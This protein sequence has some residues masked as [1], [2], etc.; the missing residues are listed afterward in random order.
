MGENGA[1]KSTLMRILAGLAQP[2][3][4]E[5]RL[6]GER[7]RLRHPYDALRRGICMIHQELLPFPEMTVAENIFMG[8]E[9]VFSQT[10]AR[11]AG[12]VDRR[13]MNQQAR[14]LLDRLGVGAPPERLMKQLSVAQMQGVEIAKALAHDA[15]LIIM[16]EPTSALSAHETDALLGTIAQL[17]AR[18]VAIVYVSHKLEEVFQVADSITVLRDGCHIA[19]EA[20]A[21]LT[22]E[23]LISLMVGR[24]LAAS[25]SVETAAADGGVILALRG[26]G[27]TGR[28][29]DVS[30]DLRR[31]E[32]LGVAGL[33]GAGRTDLLSAI[34]GLAPAD[35]G[36]IFVRGKS[37][38]IG[39][40]RAALA[41]GIALVSEDRK[42]LGLV[43]RLSVKQNVTLSSL[44]RCCRMGFV[45]S[46][47]ENCIADKQIAEFGIRTPSREQDVMNLSGGNQQKVVIAKA[48][49]TEPDILLLDE[50][51]RGI[52]VAA[53]AEVHAIVRRLARQGKAIMLVSSE[54]PEVLALSDRLLVMRQ[55]A[56]SAELNPRHTTQEEVM[57][58]A[59]IES[60]SLESRSREV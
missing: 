25:G 52:D 43:P 15:R 35:S 53:K 16:D 18:G 23:K 22:P 14:Q 17:R 26:L 29:K 32:I 41:L 30:L 20:A 55:G 38:R 54:L 49:L 46:G 59:M 37:E 7:V 28:F 44:A 39:S 1:G 12:W 58:C 45:Y 27:R 21:Q 40:P 50:P 19:T 33:M 10:L 57:R 4:G 11:A 6:D 9:P 24:E 31:G 42:T 34:Y 60:A 48:L 47:R 13:A 56:I 3:S 2:D 36:E 51:T 5:L 8:Q